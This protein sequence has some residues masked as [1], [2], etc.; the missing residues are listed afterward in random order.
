MMK[1]ILLIALSL[2]LLISTGCE[3]KNL[4]DFPAGLEEGDLIFNTAI[5]GPDRS[6]WSGSDIKYDHL[7]IIIK[8]NNRLQVFE[9]DGKVQYSSIENFIVRGKSGKFEVK[10]LKDS[11]RYLDPTVLRE[12]KMVADRYLGQQYDHQ[13]NWN[14][15]LM[16]A[17]ELVWKVF[18]EAVMID[19]GQ[20]GTL[21]DLDFSKPSMQHYVKLHFGGSVADRNV[22]VTPSTIFNS[23]YLET[24]YKK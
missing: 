22:I 12:I 15:K 5:S 13:L 11:D 20:P 17:S 4:I 1:K 3:K 7:G 9:V 19:L 14:N 16:Y 21:A 6:V 23:D 10:R 18:R 8:K 2:G 24:V